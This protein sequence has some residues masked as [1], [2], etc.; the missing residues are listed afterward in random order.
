MNPN[1][2]YGLL[3]ILT[4]A[5]TAVGA[6]PEDL[7]QTPLS[8]TQTVRPMVLL[9]LSNDHQLYRKAYN[10]YSDLDGDA[11]IDTTYNNGYSYYGYFDPNKCYTY[12][13]QRLLQSD[14]GGHHIIN[15][16]GTGQDS[17]TWSGNLLNWAAM[18]R[19]DILRRVLYGGYRSTD[20][21]D[22]TTP[23]PRP[24]SNGSCCPPTCMPLPRSSPPPAVP[25]TWRATP[26]T[27]SDAAITFCNVTYAE[28]QRSRASRS[29]P[30]P[31]R[32]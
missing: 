13:T 32:P 3:I 28:R 27:R 10:D 6:A 25:P 18:T 7:A 12:S 11:A 15:A 2:R 29:T 14:R 23:V 9:A 21:P 4:I 1:L 24:S 17:G 5:A 31:I 22:A 20:Y 19:M 16:I 26:P 8:V 30:R